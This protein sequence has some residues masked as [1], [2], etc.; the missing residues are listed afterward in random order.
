[1]KNQLPTSKKTTGFTLIELLIVIAIIAILATISMALFA[2][3]QSKARD[4][5]RRADVAEVTKAL[6]V[7][8]GASLITFPA[9]LDSIF[10]PGAIPVDPTSTQTYCI[11]WTLG[12]AGILP[13]DPT[14]ITATCNGGG[15]AVAQN[16]VTGVGN[17]VFAPMTNTVYNTSVAGAST[18][19]AYRIRVCAYLE[20]TSLTNRIVCSTTQA[21]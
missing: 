16:T 2:N 5:K 18:T 12:T 14:T 1:M 10:T 21:N 4:A 11:A 19:A 8:K 20:D 6:D 13:A 3:V 7:A 15:V 9:L 17:T